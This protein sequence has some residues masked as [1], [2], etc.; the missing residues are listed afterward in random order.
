MKKMLLFLAMTSIVSLASAQK[1][2]EK[3]VPSAVKDKFVSL[4]PSNKVEKWEKDG[5]NYDACFEQTKKKIKV[6]FSASGTLVKTETKISVIELPQ[7]VKDYANRNYPGKKISDASKVV[8]ID[9]TTTYKIE[10]NDLKL[11]IDSNGN[12]IQSKK[13]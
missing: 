4:Y 5:S 3:D 11:V 10:V 1:C 2:Q 12:L 8:D 7:T 9:N 13:D 6:T